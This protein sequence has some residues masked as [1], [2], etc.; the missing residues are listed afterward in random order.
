MALFIG[1]S[2]A[3]SS[4]FNTADAE[5]AFHPWWK[6]V[7]DYVCYSAIIIGKFI[8]DIMSNNAKMK[9]RIMALGTF[10]I[11]FLCVFRPEDIS[12]CCK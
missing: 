10:E 3:K 2:L 1:N 12:Y 9:M 5:A 7:Q 4:I 8:I 11:H 6:T